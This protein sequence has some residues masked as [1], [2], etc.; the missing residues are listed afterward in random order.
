MV[1]SY[2]ACPLGSTVVKHASNCAGMW[3]FS[4][5]PD[6]DIDR[7]VKCFGLKDE[8]AHQVKERILR[9]ALTFAKGRQ[10]RNLASMLLTMLHKYATSPSPGLLGIKRRLT[11][12]RGVQL[13]SQ[14]ARYHPALC[15]VQSLQRRS[16]TQPSGVDH[17]RGPGRSRQDMDRGPPHHNPGVLPRPNSRSVW[18]SARFTDIIW[19]Y[20]GVRAPSSRVLSDFKG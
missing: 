15:A 6:N 13:A 1:F 4:F 3:C 9:D 20:F 8:P 12:A 19:V 14:K 10:T 5:S 2:L 11:K 17:P 7:S 16:E 18:R